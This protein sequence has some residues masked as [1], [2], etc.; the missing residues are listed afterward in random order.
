[1]AKGNIAKSKVTEKIKE[2]FGADYIGEYDKKIYVWAEDGGE[3]VQIA[4][5]LTCPKVNV[6][7]AAAPPTGDFNFED[8]APTPIV[9]ASAFQPADIT[10]DE[11]ATVRQLMKDLGL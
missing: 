8:D 1:M 5:S 4:L 6:S 11:R 3:K 10:E 9:A 2:A 7:V